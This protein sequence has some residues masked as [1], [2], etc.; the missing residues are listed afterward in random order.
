M[1]E[2]WTFS[3]INS[4]SEQAHSYVDYVGASFG[5]I[6]QSPNRSYVSRLG[7]GRHYDSNYNVI[8]PD[9]ERKLD[10]EATGL[11]LGSLGDHPAI[12]RQ[13]FVKF[14]ICALFI[15]PK[16]DTKP[17]NPKAFRCVVHW[18]PYDTVPNQGIFK[19]DSLTYWRKWGTVFPVSASHKLDDFL[20]QKSTIK[21]KRYPARSGRVGTPKQKWLPTGKSAPNPLETAKAWL[22]D[23]QNDLVMIGHSQGVNIA[24]AVLKTGFDWP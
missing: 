2:L 4:W 8:S 1:P 18:S 24:M 21:L 7:T 5:D 22:G 16:T 13:Q 19:R 10:A 20:A 23:E 3:G 12:E 9:A 11:A 17:H 15:A 14:R 6:G